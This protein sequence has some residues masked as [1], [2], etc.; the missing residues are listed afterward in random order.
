LPQGA[1]DQL[2]TRTAGLDGQKDIMNHEKNNETAPHG[3]RYDETFK[4]HAVELS[5]RGDRKIGA[6]AQELGVTPWTL[7]LWRKR[8]APQPTGGGGTAAQMT[9]EQKDEEIR[10]LRAELV[11][12]RE[13]ETILKKS[14]GILSETPRSGIPG[15]KL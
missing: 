13:R 4:R 3:R 8:Y 2:G 5:V 7:R 15:S 6:V 1:A 11:R 10:R 14:V 9:P 12:M